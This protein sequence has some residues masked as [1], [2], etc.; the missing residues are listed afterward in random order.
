MDEDGKYYDYDSLIMTPKSSFLWE[1]EG[2]PRPWPGSSTLVYLNGAQ[3]QEA[4]TSKQQRN[5]PTI[6]CPSEVGTLTFNLKYK[7]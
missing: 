5:V 3:L 4:K 7:N 1:T 6:S 2:G